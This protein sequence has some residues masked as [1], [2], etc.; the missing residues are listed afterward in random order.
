MRNISHEFFENLPHNRF[1]I[2]SKDIFGTFDEDLLRKLTNIPGL[3]FVEQLETELPTVEIRRMDT[4]SKAEIDG[5]EVLVHIEFQVSRESTPEI[6]KRKVGY[7]GRCFERYGLP[8]LS[9]TVYLRSEAGRNDPGEYRQDFPNHNVLI[10]Y[11]VIR[12]SEFDGQSIFDTDQTSLMAF[13]P[14]MRPPEGVSEV[15]WIE[16]CHQMTLALPIASDLQ[17]NLLIW[18]WILSGL[19]VD[20]AEIRH[21]LEGPMLESSTYRYIL[22]QGIEQ[23]I[24]K[25]IKKGIEKGIEQ[26]ARESTIEGILESL[27]IQFHES[28]IQT[29]KPMLES[30]QDLQR[31]KDLRR[32]AMQV[33]SLETFKSLLTTDA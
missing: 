25:G 15:E 28:G 27:E 20:P 8:I 1:D 18:Q 4:L 22:Q 6:L 7:F 21:L 13:T 2:V 11:Q 33:P 17:N 12:L 19:I 30:I 3:K 26:G 5:R 32:A 10:A 14:L 9:F 23:G 16:Q 29:L 31:L 24:E